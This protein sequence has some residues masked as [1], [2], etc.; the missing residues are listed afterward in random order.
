[1]TRQ[2]ELEAPAT[3][4]AIREPPPAREWRGQDYA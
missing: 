1:M 2:L 3:A 4:L